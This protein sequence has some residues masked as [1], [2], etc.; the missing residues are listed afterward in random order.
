MKPWITG[1]VW[2]PIPIRNAGRPFHRPEARWSMTV[3]IS[4]AAR[5]AF[6]HCCDVRV[7]TSENGKDRVSHVLVDGPVVFEDDRRKVVEHVI[8]RLNRRAPAPFLRKAL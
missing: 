6:S 4:K 2:M 5:A 8:E 7:R 3:C 1:P